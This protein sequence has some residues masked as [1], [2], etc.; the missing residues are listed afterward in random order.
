MD[1]L[2]H[3]V[4]GV[5]VHQAKLTITTLVGSDPRQLKR[6]TWE[7]STY[8]DDLVEAA[9]KIKS[10]GVVEVAM[11]SSGIYWRP[12]FNVWS[13]MGLNITLGNAYHIKNVP[14]RKTDVKDSEWL[15]TLHRSGLIRPSYIPEEEFRILRELT[16]HRE[17]LISNVIDVK[18][19][20]QH[21]LE[22]GNIKLQSAL[23]DVFG[24]AGR[25]VLMAIIAGETD[26]LKLALLVDTNVKSKLEVIKKSLEHRL[27][28]TNRFC[29]KQLYSHLLYLE[30][31]MFE[32]QSEI[33]QKMKPYVDYLKRLDEIPGVD[34]K[35]AEVIIAEATTEM[36]NFKDAKTFAAWAGVAAGNH[37]S[38]GK[39]KEQNAEE[40]TQHCERH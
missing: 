14:G 27:T 17:N 38:A 31:M 26:A 10:F 37:E 4:A 11:E 36:K 23:S 32:L 3:A 5:D 35:T 29:L 20:I 28:E 25:K 30:Q 21:V 13:K 8:T 7:C 9:K 16:R 34:K 24:V 6:T 22:D 2:F 18:N 19:R 15:A 12:V 40:E 33:D 1:S 39:K